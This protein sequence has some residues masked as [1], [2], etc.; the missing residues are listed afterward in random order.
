[1]RVEPASVRS[2]PLE[3]VYRKAGAGSPD[4]RHRTGEVSP[5]DCHS[6][7]RCPGT[8]RKLHTLAWIDLADPALGL[9]AEYAALGGVPIWAAL[10]CEVSQEPLAW[11]RSDPGRGRSSTRRWSTAPRR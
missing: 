9:A 3:I 7:P 5:T 1:M 8:R 4:E 10:D 2:E 6:V 11:R